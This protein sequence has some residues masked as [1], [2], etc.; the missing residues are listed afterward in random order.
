MVVWLDSPETLVA[1]IGDGS[2][3]MIGG[4]LFTRM[5]VAALAALCSARP[6]DLHYLSWGGGFPLEMLLEVDA[7]TR[8]TLCFS[9]LDIFGP[10]PRFRAAVE[11]DELELIELNAHLFA[12]SLSAGKRRLASE[13]ATWP[14]ASDLTGLEGYPPSYSDPISNERVGAAPAIRP[15]YLLLH[16]QAADADGNIEIWGSRG[17]D[18]AAI[19]A[20]RSVLVTV[21]EI[22]PREALGAAK[23]SIVI[24]RHFTSA[25]AVVPGGAAPTSCLPYYLAD[26][27]VLMDWAASSTQS[28]P[29]VAADAPRVELSQVTVSAVAGAVARLP[30]DEG[31]RE[32]TVD[33]W[34]AC[35]MSR[36]YDDGAI[37]SVG[38]VSPLAT[39]SYLL[40]KAN[41]A[42]G[43]TLM[44]NGGGY[45]DVSGRPLLFGLG[46]WLDAISAVTQCGG[47]E[48]YEWY[49]QAGLVTHEVVSVAQIDARGKTN[50]R[51]VFSPSGRRIRLPGQGGMADVADMHRDFFIY[52]PRQSA[53]NTPQSVA[54]TSAA[55]SLI[56][57]EER[58]RAGY[59][60]GRVRM[61]SNLAVFEFDAG[62]E[63]MIAR[64]LFP[65]TT[66]EQLLE[67]TG[68]FLDPAE[69][70]GLPLVTPPTA[71]EL[72]LLRHTV[73]P[74]GIRR[75]E[76]A[77]S[78][79]RLPILKE[80]LD[81]ERALIRSV[82]A[83]VEAD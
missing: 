2:S 46:E 27:P 54:F 3:V 63:R 31:S 25:I 28:T 40:A 72:D 76:F 58:R 60:P 19:P 47:E 30:R 35:W 56:G 82:L 67:A 18:L 52:L 45:I 15:D 71:I 29:P 66:V 80:T 10:A 39:A 16:A 75:L 37:C 78:R 57:A 5:P 50:N 9:S 26:Y 1:G 62:A 48:S 23:G 69:L 34:M 8:A 77:A 70:V 14:T 17:L 32:A 21:E 53:L 36:Q 83:A 81:A 44:T 6:R 73:D 59:Q 74:F 79:D 33:E 64:E 49:Y 11:N 38:A 43:L 51:E 7:V 42:P 22:K 41:H 61:V 12:Q 4:A 24:P 55:R 65:W 68:F 13:P 20:A